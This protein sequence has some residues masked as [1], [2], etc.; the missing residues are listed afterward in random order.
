VVQTA[1]IALE[2]ENLGVMSEKFIS[3]SISISEYAYR[4]E[5]YL[6]PASMLL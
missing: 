2:P 1:Q 5:W 6:E 3:A 4:D